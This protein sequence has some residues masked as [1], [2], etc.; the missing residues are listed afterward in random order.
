MDSGCHMDLTV[1]DA[2]CDTLTRA[3]G[4]RRLAEHLQDSQVDLPRLIEGGV[5]AQ[6]FAIC[7][8]RL[9]PA[10][11][12]PRALAVVD[13]LYREVEVNS[14]RLRLA[15]KMDDIRCAKQNGLVAALMSF[16]SVEPLHEDLALLRVF[17]RL[18]LRCIGLT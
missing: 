9:S 15:T 13:Y 7:L 6:I 5:T 2:H 14:D 1:F 18:G 17:Y 16:E 12:T 3:L 10:Q 11:A 4:K 8:A